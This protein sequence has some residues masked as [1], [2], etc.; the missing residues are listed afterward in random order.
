MT[1]SVQTARRGWA[2]SANVVNTQPL[3]SILARS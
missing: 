3:E 1:F 2:T